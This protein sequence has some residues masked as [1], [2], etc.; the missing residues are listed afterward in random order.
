MVKARI[1]IKPVAWTG[2]RETMYQGFASWQANKDRSIQI[3]G[4]PA[5]TED[6]ALANL[7]DEYALWKIFVSLVEYELEEFKSEQWNGK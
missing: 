1:K 2:D 6:L 3:V 5:V 4:E 7:E